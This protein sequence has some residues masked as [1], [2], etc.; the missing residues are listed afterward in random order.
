MA[1]FR[2]DDSDERDMRLEDHGQHVRV[3]D[4]Y[5]EWDG[6]LDAAMTEAALLCDGV[7][8]ELRFEDAGIVLTVDMPD[9]ETVAVAGLREALAECMTIL[10]RAAAA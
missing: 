4:F 1:A 3:E 9:P 2:P 8:A 10:D 6:A 7:D 5:A